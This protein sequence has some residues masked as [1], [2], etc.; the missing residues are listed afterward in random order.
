LQRLGLTSDAVAH[1]CVLG[2]DT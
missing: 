2:K 1:R